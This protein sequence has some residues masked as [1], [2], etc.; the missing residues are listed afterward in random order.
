MCDACDGR[1]PSASPSSPR[2]STRWNR[3]S[4]R[5]Y[6]SSHRCCSSS[7]HHRRHHRHRRQ[8][9]KKNSTP[10]HCSHSVASCRSSRKNCNSPN[11]KGNGEGTAATSS[12]RGWRRASSSAADACPT[13]GTRSRTMRRR[14]RWNP[15]RASTPWHCRWYSRLVLHRCCCCCCCRRRRYHHRHCRHRAYSCIPASAWTPATA[16]ASPWKSPSSFGE[17]R[18]RRSDARRGRRWRRCW[19]RIDCRRCFRCCCDGRTTT[20]LRRRRRFRD[21]SP[22]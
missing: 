21:W 9:W 20:T 14:K 2:C 17:S 6:S 11:R 8:P 10:C 19:R 18:A 22:W 4:H 13:W 1:C 5:R 15:K 3:S 16:D 12:W 7:R